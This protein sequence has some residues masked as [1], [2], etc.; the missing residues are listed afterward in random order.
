MEIEELY[1]LFKLS[2]GITTDTRNIQKDNLFFALKGEKFNGNGFA[3]QAIQDGAAYA[4]VDDASLKGKERMIYCEDVLETLQAL[5][6]H[7]RRQFDIAVIALTGSNGKTTNKELLTRV[8]GQ[9]Y[10]VHATKGNLNNHIGVPLTL[11]S[12]PDDAQVAII[13]MGANHQKEIA[14]LCS[15]AEPTHGFI[16]NLGKAH[17]EGFGGEEGIRKGKGELFDFLKQSGGIVFVNANDPKVRALAEER[18]ILPIVYYGDDED[19][20]L[21]KE[22]SPVVVFE[23]PVSGKTYTTFIG[24]KYNFDNMQ[25]AHAIGRYFDVSEDKA[26]EAIAHYNP[27]NNRSQHVMVGTNHFIMDA[28]NANPSSMEASLKSFGALKTDSPKV[29]VLGDMYELGDY[30]EAEHAAIGKLLSE[31][32][33]DDVVL[34]GENMKAA[35]AFLPK[36]YYFTDKFSMHNWLLDRKYENTYIL[37]KGSRSTGL[38]SVL[39]AFQNAG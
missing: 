38:E 6:R 20:L 28:Y 35:L 21:I 39:K 33:F 4:V 30:S 27:D 14:L 23:S 31:L 13:E 5:A 25:T 24:G 29:V 26:C 32:K 3:E 1:S 34:F 10:K 9:K 11:L 22:E 15:I 8:L 16:T 17:L 37:V 18:N 7:H 12:M 36:A 19:A 2:S